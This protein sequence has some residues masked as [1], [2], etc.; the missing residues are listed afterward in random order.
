MAYFIFLDQSSVLESS[1]GFVR[2]RVDRTD[3]SSFETVFVSTVQN[4]N[5]NGT[6]NNNDYAPLLD[7]AVSFSPGFFL[8]DYIYVFTNDDTIQEQNETF[9]LILENSFGGFLTSA[10]FTILNDDTPPVAGSVSVSDY[11]IT[12]GDNGTSFATFTLTRSGGTAA[13]SVS[14]ATADGSASGGGDYGAAFGTVNFGLNETTRQISIPVFGDLTFEGNETFF[15]NL[16]GATNGAS[17]SDGQG[18]GTILNDDAAPASVS[19]S[20]GTTDEGGNLIFTV[21]RSGGTLGA[22]LTINYLWGGTASSGQDYESPSG[23]VTIAANQLTAQIVIPTFSDAVNEPSETVELTMYGASTTVNFVTG[24]AT[25]TI[26]NVPFAEPPPGDNSHYKFFDDHRRWQGNLVNWFY[27]GVSSPAAGAGS[28]SSQ[29]ARAFQAWQGTDSKIVFQQVFDASL[30]DIHVGWTFIGSSPDGNVLG[31]TIPNSGPALDDGSVVI[32]F[33]N[34][35]S[36]VWNGADYVLGT[37]TFYEL[38]LHEIGHAIGL[39]H[40]SPAR[41]PDDGSLMHWDASGTAT[42]LTASEWEAARILYPFSADPNI[43]T[44]RLANTLW[45]ALGGNDRV[46][47]TAGTDSIY[48]DAGADELF[49]AGATDYLDGGSENDTLRGGMGRDTLAGGSGSD[50]FV[51]ASTAESGAAAIARDVIIDFQRGTALT[52][53]NI[54]LRLI[55]A[56]TGVLGNNA[57]KFIGAQAFHHVK[58]EVHYKDAGAH[59]IVEGDVNGDGRSDFS[60]LVLNVVG[61]SAGDFLL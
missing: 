39:D 2:F 48:G 5:G 10:S 59:V 25:G 42:N 11:T 12:E 19:I 23:S 43:V 33:D 28:Y 24:S 22:P 44:L 37:T 31:H 3:A 60:V 58:G 21:T 50:N 8:S 54:D 7:F 40:P 38:A 20:G 52:G 26:N 56:K 1:P 55:D 18:L 53:D 49:G 6:F 29:V 46:T 13:F 47:G 14:Y 17:I 16:S 32:E 34:E 27:D 9:G 35:E 41:S 36:W 61:L 30:A 45:H 4:W 15:V 57:F 51:F